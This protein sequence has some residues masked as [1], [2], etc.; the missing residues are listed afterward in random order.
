MRHQLSYT[1]PYNLIETGGQSRHG[2]GDVLLNYRFQAY[3][4]E[5]TLTA[6]APRF[7]LVLPTGDE[8]TASA[9]TQSAIN[10]CCRSAPRLATDGFFTPMPGSRFCPTRASDRLTIC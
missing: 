10:G 6:F 9:T 4:D 1:V 3:Y 7:S 5:K 2:V 8:R